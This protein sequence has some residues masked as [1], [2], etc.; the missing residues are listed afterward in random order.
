MKKIILSLLGATGILLST[1]VASQSFE[2]FSVGVNFQTSDFDIK[3][4]EHEQKDSTV[5][6][7]AQET[8]AFVKRS[9]STDI[10]EGFII[11]LLKVQQLV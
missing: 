1:V 10:V 7:G 8:S 11:L 9:I 2:G 4:R 3:G 6:G 5:A